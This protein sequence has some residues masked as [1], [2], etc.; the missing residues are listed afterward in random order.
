MATDGTWS[1][2]PQAPGEAFTVAISS[3]VSGDADARLN[4]HGITRESLKRSGFV[5][6]AIDEKLDRLDADQSPDSE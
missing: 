4:S 1:R 3:K 5:R 2:K 6:E